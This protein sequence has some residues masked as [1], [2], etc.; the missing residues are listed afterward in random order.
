MANSRKYVG[1]EDSRL[2]NAL[3]FA[4]HKQHPKCSSLSLETVCGDDCFL[5]FGAFFALLELPVFSMLFLHA[6]LKAEWSILL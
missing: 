1:S 6:R 2:I 3:D 5:V 4:F